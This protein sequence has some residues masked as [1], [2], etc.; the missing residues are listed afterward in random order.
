MPVEST[1]GMP[2]APAWRSRGMFTR[3]A[4]QILRR[5]TS[6]SIIS[7]RLTWSQAEAKNTMPRSSA[8]S[9]SSAISSMDSSRARRCSP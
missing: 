2:Q 3:S 8:I 1:T 7:A 5:S 9:L 6:R 4:E